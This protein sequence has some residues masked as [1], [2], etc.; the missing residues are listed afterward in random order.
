M[1][2]HVRQKDEGWRK[3]VFMASQSPNYV[4]LASRLYH[5]KPHSIAWKEITLNY[6]FVNVHN[7]E[8]VEGWFSKITCEK[9]TKG[10]WNS[11]NIPTK[12]EFFARNHWPQMY[13]VPKHELWKTTTMAGPWHRRISESSLVLPSLCVQECWRLPLDIG[14][15]PG[16]HHTSRPQHLQQLLEVTPHSHGLV[17]MGK[18]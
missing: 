14:W 13:Q 1:F 7:S 4:L 5:Y 11:A 10:S 12:L 3:R 2:L 17:S 9:I 15:H 6:L 8:N 18:I 16:C